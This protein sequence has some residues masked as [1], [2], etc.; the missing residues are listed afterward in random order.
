MEVEMRLSRSV[1]AKAA[2][3]C[4]VLLT[5]LALAA[6]TLAAEATNYM[7]VSR[8]LTLY[9]RPADPRPNAPAPAATGPFWPDF[10]GSYVPAP[11]KPETDG[12]SRDPEDCASGC[13]DN[14]G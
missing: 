12:L 6:P 5:T 10:F 9:H 2:L 7:P 13:I 4:S 1:S 8:D 11:K 3:A 14:G